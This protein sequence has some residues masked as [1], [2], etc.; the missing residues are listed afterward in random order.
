MSQRCVNRGI[1]LDP[2]RGAGNYVACL[3][4]IDFIKHF[5]LAKGEKSPSPNLPLP[6]ANSAVQTPPKQKMR[7]LRACSRSS[8]TG[9]GDSLGTK[10]MGPE[11]GTIQECPSIHFASHYIFC[12][13]SLFFVLK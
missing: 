9:R 12:H 13:Y 6:Q 2:G 5:D 10:H 1:T 11:G 4:G 8:A 7:V 3:K